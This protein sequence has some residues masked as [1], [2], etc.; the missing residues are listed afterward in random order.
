MDLTVQ[1]ETSS[2]A[3]AEKRGSIANRAFNEILMATVITREKHAEKEILY[4]CV[5]FSKHKTK[6]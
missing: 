5:L 4:N 1:H 3:Q 6:M 2:L